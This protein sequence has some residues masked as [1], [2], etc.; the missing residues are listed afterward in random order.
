VKRAT[1]RNLIRGA[2]YAA[3]LAAAVAL[4]WSGAAGLRYPWDWG[5]FFRDW[6]PLLLQGLLLTLKVAAL[7]L[8]LALP[9]GVAVGLCRI[10]RDPVARWLGTAYVEVVRGTP[11]LVQVMLWY[12]V[13]GKVFDLR[14][15]GAAV[16]ALSCFT[17]SYIAEIVRAGIQSIDPGQMEA[18]RSLG[19]SHFQAL[20]TIILPQA[21]RRVLPPLASE[22]V[23][24]VKDSSLASVVGYEELTKRAQDVQGRAFLT[25]EVWIAAAA[26]YL[27]VNLVLSLAVRLLEHKLGVAHRREEI[28]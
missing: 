26:L 27:A 3:L 19:L 20:R 5:R 14:S 13:I 4:V 21:I 23:A 11:L 10:A 15:F 7:S 22:F 17:A 8:C 1:R 28:R 6:S 25:F 2:V 24:L 18:A 12:F 16:A 9:L